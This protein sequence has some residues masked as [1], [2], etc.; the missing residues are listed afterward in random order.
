[1]E[2]AELE[3]QTADGQCAVQVYEPEQD[4]PWPAVIVYMDAIGVRPA[5]MEIAERIA[6]EGYFVML[7]DL[8]Y[9]IPEFDPSQ[10]MRLFTDAEFRKDMMARVIPSASAANVMRDTEHFLKFLHDQPDVDDARLGITGYCMG[11]RLALYAAGHLGERIAA[12]ASY[13]PGGVATDAPD[14]AHRMAPGIRGRVYIGRAIDDAGFDDAAK[15]R[16]EEAYRAANV[17]YELETY[18]A[19]HGFVPRDTPVHD[20]SAAARHW[21]TLLAL[22]GQ[23]LRD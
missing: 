18:N 2:H 3:I 1:M 11:G 8:F 13:H 15:A 6:N 19:K 22:F 23:T 4:G 17:N 21:Q 5:L 9:R 7:P 14:S 20:R 10:G 12:V 16:L